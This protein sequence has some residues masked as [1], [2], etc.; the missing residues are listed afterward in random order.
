MCQLSRLPL[1]NNCPTPPWGSRPTGAEA[2]RWYETL[3][4][5]NTNGGAGS[6]R[7]DLL[8]TANYGPIV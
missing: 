5:N 2:R 3:R 8:A 4:L 1:K 7:T 6:Q